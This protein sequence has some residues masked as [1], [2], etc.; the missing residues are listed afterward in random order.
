MK[1]AILL[2]LISLISAPAMA[3]KQVIFLDG[4]L[5]WFYSMPPY[6]IEHHEEVEKLPFSGFV[7]VGN[8]YTSYTMSADPNSNNVTYSRVWNEVKSL[9][10]VYKNKTHNFLRINLDFPGDFWDDAV[11]QKTAD[12]FAAVAEAAKNIGFKGILFD[13]EVYAGGQHTQAH[14]MSNFKFPKRLDVENN[15]GNYEDWE[16]SESLENRGD[17][18][19]YKCRIDGQTVENSEDCSYRNPAYTFKEHMDKVASRF[20]DIMLAMEAKY[21]NITM[22]V[23]HGPATAHP[24]TNIAGHYIK[25]NSIF[26]TNEYKGAMFLGLKQGLNGSARLH[27]MGEFYQYNTDQHFQNSYQW[28]KHD[29][30]SEAYNQGLDDT[31]RWIVPTD[32]RASWSNDVK[33]GFMVSDYGLKHDL[34]EYDIENSCH[35][36]EVES[37]LTKA[38]DKSDEYV[39]YYSDSELSIC[40]NDIRWTDISGPV[41]PAWLNMMQGVYDDTRAVGILPG[42]LDLILSGSSPPGE[43]VVKP[44]YQD[45]A[46]IPELTGSWHG[47][48]GEHPVR[49]LSMPSPWPD[50]S[51]NTERNIDLYFPSDVSGKKPTVFFIAGWNMSHSERYK[52]FL[53]FIASQGFNS[54]FVPYTGGDAIGNPAVLLNILDGIVDGPWENMINTDKVGYSGHSSGGGLVFYLAQ[55]RPDWGTQG[56]FL[57]PVA[58]WWGYHLPETGDLLFPANTNMIVQVSHDDYGTDPRQNIDFLLHS[59]I[60]TERKSYLYLPGDDNHPSNHEVIYSKFEN[61]IYSYDAL[62]QVGLYRPLESLMRYSFGT[63]DGVE[64]KAI[65][66]PDEGD[67]NYNMMYTLNGIS[68]LSTDDPLGNVSIPIPLE[69]NLD[70][71]YLCNKSDDNPRYK[72]CMPCKN[73]PR[74]QAWE[75]CPAN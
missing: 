71:R 57:F 10:D 48:M 63:P 62:D 72:M 55:Q 41:E 46:N 59:N 5:G 7:V 36:A 33:A 42:I 31:Y 49:K 43:A 40:E 75:E 54:V 47:A 19:D 18:V 73:T 16:I 14:Y 69:Q 15:P 51:A 8:V 6:L 38:L 22:L 2:L 56:R 64:W 30:V 32:D 61:G 13:D 44:S 70:P 29:I 66:L 34:P 50:Y 21:P 28:R 52:S 26:E 20:K 60:S 24:K 3:Q 65:G 58:A 23:L 68:V 74:D 11:W 39:I 17:W 25:P 12:N 35:P 9:K 45:A 1:K 4:Y 27:D 53:Y 67:A 37:R